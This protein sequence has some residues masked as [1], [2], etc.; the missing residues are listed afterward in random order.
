MAQLRE[1]GSR[2]Q[3][4]TMVDPMLIKIRPDANARD[5]QSAEVKAHIE[6]LAASILAQGFLSS[7]PLE[8]VV[9]GDDV[10]VLAGFC[11][12]S[13]CQL[14][15]SRG[16]DIMAIPCLPEAKGTS[17]AQRILN[18]FTSNTGLRLT[19]GEEGKV[20]KRLIALGYTPAT[21]AKEAGCSESHVRQAL[22]F[23]AAPAEV[24]KMVSEGKVSTS[25]AA[26]TMREQG[27]KG[28]AKLQ[29]AV[30]TAQKSGKTKATAKH[31]E[32]RE[33]AKRT[34]RSLTFDPTPD[35]CVA[36]VQ[37]LARIDDPY[38]MDAGE[39]LKTLAAFFKEAKALLMQPARSAA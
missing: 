8:V 10:F 16:V 30:E 23:N 11:R 22:E 27:S 5:M 38:E 2:S 34:P 6:A 18:Q 20:F 4:V 26:K 24:H 28:V 9:E 3:T 25:L 36:L 35:S 31:V 7:H 39:T 1:I 17:Q 21:V 33:P 14:L 32:P 29:A 13:A 12:L 15:R 19:L 37:R